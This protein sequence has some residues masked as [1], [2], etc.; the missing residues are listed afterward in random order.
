M[1]AIPAVETFIL[2]GLAWAVLLDP[3]VRDAKPG[4][5]IVT[6]SPIMLEMI[7]RTL[8]IAGRTDVMVKLQETPHGT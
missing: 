4:A 7:E 5:V 8:Q 2:P 1:T 6:Y 3:I